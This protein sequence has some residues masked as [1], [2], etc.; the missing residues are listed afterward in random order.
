M[1]QVTNSFICCFGV[2]DCR[3]QSIP[4]YLAGK[5]Q[6][7]STLDTSHCFKRTDHADEQLHCHKSHCKVC[8]KHS[9]KGAGTLFAEDCSLPAPWPDLTVQKPKVLGHHKLRCVD[10]SHSCGRKNGA[11]SAPMIPT[12]ENPMAEQSLQAILSLYYLVVA[13]VSFYNTDYTGSG[14][15]FM[16]VSSQLQSKSQ[17]LSSPKT[18]WMESEELLKKTTGHEITACSCLNR[19]VRK[20]RGAAQPLVLPLPSRHPRASPEQCHTEQE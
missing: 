5:K 3:K 16:S 19:A 10:Y 12:Q 20:L 18:S 2:R 11:I 6:G 1:D 7:T 8:W 15:S 17:S 4:E 9:D 13:Q 14:K